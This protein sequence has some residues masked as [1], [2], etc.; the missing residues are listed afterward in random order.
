MLSGTHATCRLGHSLRS[1]FNSAAS[2]CH[3]GH[4]LFMKFLTNW[5]SSLF[6]GQKLS[7]HF[8]AYEKETHRGVIFQKPEGHLVLWLNLSLVKNSVI[9]PSC[10]PPQ[11]KPLLECFFSDLFYAFGVTSTFRPFFARLWISWEHEHVLF[12]LLDLAWIRYLTACIEWV[13]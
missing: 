7:F 11:R 12:I 1:G 2:S 4:V 6:Q 9:P 5:N 13:E 8:V 3:S 10:S